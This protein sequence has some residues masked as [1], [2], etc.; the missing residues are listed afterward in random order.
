[1][2]K[3]YNKLRGAMNYINF[4]SYFDSKIKNSNRNE[5]Y[6]KIFTKNFIY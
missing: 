5:F 6:F 3:I 2:K 4:I 1:M